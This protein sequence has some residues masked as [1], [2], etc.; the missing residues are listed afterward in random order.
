MTDVHRWSPYLVDGRPSESVKRATDKASGAFAL[1]HRGRI[2]YVGASDAGYL[3]QAIRRH[4]THENKGRKRGTCEVTWLVTS[5]GVRGSTKRDTSATALAKRWTNKFRKAGHD[6]QNRDDQPVTRAKVANPQGLLTELGR[7][8][9]LKFKRGGDEL[10]LGWNL[11]RAPVLAYDEAGRLHVVYVGAIE[12]ASSAKEL[13]EYKRTHWGA[14]PTGKVRA[15][16]AGVPPWRLLGEGTEIT[17]T[18]RKGNDTKPVDY[19]HEWGEGG[20]S[21]FT[22]P[23]VVEHVCQGGC[24]KGCGARDMLALSGGSYVV[25]ERGIVG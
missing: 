15:G 3:W 18:T 4:A 17:Y 5:R 12:R 11:H 14:Q 22:A 20:P 13:K 7:L 25:S 24:A 1:R 2:V 9:L 8:T 6:L 21:R 23:R 16:L 10:E 19:V